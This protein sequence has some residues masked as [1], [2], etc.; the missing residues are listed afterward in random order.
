MATAEPIATDGAPRSDVAA[1]TTQEREAQGLG[2]TVTSGPRWRQ[3]RLQAVNRA[4]S[5]QWLMG[6]V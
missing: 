4:L 5:G 2:S 3:G 1:R 6:R